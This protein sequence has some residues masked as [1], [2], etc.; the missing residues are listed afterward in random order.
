MI[1]KTDKILMPV[2]ILCIIIASCTIL[3][4]THVIVGLIA[5]FIGI[6]AS[7]YGIYNC[8]KTSEQHKIEQ[9]QS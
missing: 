3:Y 6:L 1:S 5:A 4:E 2:T 9:Q 7:V 8:I